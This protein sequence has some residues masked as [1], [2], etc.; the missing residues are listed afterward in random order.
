MVLN[1]HAYLWR[2]VYRA[3]VDRASD[4]SVAAVV[5]HGVV[6]HG[7]LS[8]GSWEVIG[9]LPGQMAADVDRYHSLLLGVSLYRPL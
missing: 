1:G 7:P 6:V 8:L 5:L 2:E 9:V 4:G 3:G